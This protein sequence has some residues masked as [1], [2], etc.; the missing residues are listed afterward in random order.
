LY[1]LHLDYRIAN[2]GVGQHAHSGDQV[3][4]FPS[5]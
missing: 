5:A 2:A 3:P 4:N 1:T